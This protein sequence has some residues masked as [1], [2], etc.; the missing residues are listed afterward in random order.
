MWFNFVGKS[1]MAY[2]EI[3]LTLAQK[4]KL[5]SEE[6]RKPHMFLHFEKSMITQI[7]SITF[8]SC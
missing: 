6:Q 1:A 5:I 7:L 4:Q 3:F 2:Y 8:K